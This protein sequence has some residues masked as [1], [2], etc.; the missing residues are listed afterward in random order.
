MQPPVEAVDSCALAASVSIQKQFG[1][2][3]EKLGL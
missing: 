1:L 3:Q 2:I